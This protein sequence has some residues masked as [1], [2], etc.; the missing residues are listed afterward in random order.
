[1]PEIDL[2][3]VAIAA[4]AAANAVAAPA[5]P[6]GINLALEPGIAL[7]G[8]DFFLGPADDHIDW[9]VIGGAEMED[10]QYDLGEEGELQGLGE[11]RFLSPRCGPYRVTPFGFE[12]FVWKFNHWENTGL[13]D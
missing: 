11:C 12:R 6:V 5:G 2:L 7:L 10:V 9:D 13:R 1:M 4:P 3:A 8:F